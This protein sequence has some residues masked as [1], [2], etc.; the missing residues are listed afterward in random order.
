[1]VR[2]TVVGTYPRIGDTSGE[3]ALRRAIAR[4]DRREASEADV[5]AAEREVVKAVLREQAAA[6]IDVVTDGQ[7]PWYDSQSHIARGLDGVEIGGLVRYFDTNTYYRQPIVTGA[8]RWTRPLLVDEWRFAQGVS[9]APVKAVLTGPVT[10]ASLALDRHYGK[11]RGLPLA[12]ADALAEEVA[13]LESAG[14]RH[15]QVDEPILTRRPEDLPLVRDTLETLAG[16]KGA[17]ELTL[18]TY[19]GDVAK[20]YRDLVKLPAD[21]IG[22]DLVQGSK[23]WSHVQRHGSEKPLSLGV[24]DARNTKLEEPEVLASRVHELRDGVDLGRS[25]LSPSNG[26]EFLPRES[27]RQKLAVLAET[28]RRVGGDA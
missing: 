14:A 1:M 23:T 18:A 19:F 26:L 13:V 20:I 16:R 12:L 24:V 22:L 9:K 25:Y 27:A 5:R 3:Q 28:A 7:V 10:L 11:K 2:T 6:G 21:V 15:I 17:A 8:V 4:F